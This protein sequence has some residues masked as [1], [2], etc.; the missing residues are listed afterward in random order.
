MTVF[1]ENGGEKQNDIDL[2]I[3]GFRFSDLFDPV[4]LKDL[5]ERFYAEVGKSDEVL[6]TALHLHDP[7]KRQFDVFW[8]EPA[9]GIGLSKRTSSNEM[10]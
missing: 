5:A 10:L 2:G 4:R 8:C 7:G 1:S 9:A 3:D 6:H